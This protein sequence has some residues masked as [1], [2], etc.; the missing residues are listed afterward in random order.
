MT[1]EE[2]AKKLGISK[3]YIGKVEHRTKVSEKLLARVKA[4]L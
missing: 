1:R 2:L 4:V 3:S